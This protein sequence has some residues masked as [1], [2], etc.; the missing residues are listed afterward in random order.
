RPSYTIKTEFAW[1][2]YRHIHQRELLAGVCKINS[3]N[4]IYFQAKPLKALADYIYVLKY[5]WSS[6][7]PVIESLRIERER[8]ETLTSNDFDELQGNYYNANV[9]N[10]LKGI[11]KELGV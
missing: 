9:E 5:N 4:N 11:R 8:I 2:S 6:L 7:E 3:G 1:F 10:F